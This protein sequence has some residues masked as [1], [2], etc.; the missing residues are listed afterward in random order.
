MTF[1]TMTDLFGDRLK[2]DVSLARYTASRVGGAA[3][4]LLMVNSADD[5]AE[6]VNTLWAHDLPFTILGGGSNV[7]V[8]DTGVPGLTVL[9]KAKAFRFDKAA[10]TL[11]AESGTN[12]GALARQAARKGLSGL[13]WAAGVPGTIGGAVFGNAGAH[14]G[15]MAANLRVADILHKEQGKQTWNVQ[16]FEF[17]YRTSALKRNPGAVVLTA[18]LELTP[19]EPETIQAKMDQFLQHR[20]RTQPPG[21]SMGSMFKNPPGDYAGRLIEQAGLKGLRIG[22]AQ[23]SELHA[24][25]FLNHG[26]ATAQDIYQLIQHAQAEVETRFGVKLQLEIEL[27]GTF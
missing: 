6:T 3:E 20:R 9:N 5:L 25:F 11:W 14:D 22:D 10:A 17:G 19:A 24:N 23:I 1:P 15:D 26:K 7:L 8:S 12:F 27:L 18:T 21:A 2:R 13:E 16:D 4:M